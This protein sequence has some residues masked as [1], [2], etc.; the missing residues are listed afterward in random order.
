VFKG[1]LWLLLR[2]EW[3]IRMVWEAGRKGG[4]SLA[5]HRGGGEK[6]RQVTHILN[7]KVMEFH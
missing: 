6:W 1:P 5:S 7:A 2:T 4:P 3:T